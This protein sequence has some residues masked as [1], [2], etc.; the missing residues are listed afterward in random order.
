MLTLVQ[1]I[2]AFLNPF[3]CPFI[4]NTPIRSNVGT[5]SLRK[6]PDLPVEVWLEIF[7]FATYVHRNVTIK[8]LDPFTPKRTTTNAL[9]ANTPLSAMRTK[10]SL[11][12]VSKSWR[13]VAQQMLYEHIAIRSPPRA[14]IILNALKRSR[15][16]KDSENQKTN[17]NLGYGQFVRH[18]EVYTFARGSGEISY[19]QTVFKIL[20]YCPNLRTLSG[21][22][23]HY[24]PPEFLDAIAKLLGPSV[25]EFYWN[26]RDMSPGMK[27]NTST[28]P[29]FVGSFKA[30]RVLDLR[31]FVGSDPLSWTQSSSRPVLP[32]VQ[33]LILSTYSSSLD[34][35]AHLSL[36]CL[37]NLFLRTPVWGEKHEPSL[38]VFLKVHGP[39]LVVVDLT[40][41]SQDTEPIPDSS[42]P[43]RAASHIPPDIFLSPGIC[44]NLETLVFPVT[45]PIIAPHMHHHLRRIGL[46]GGNTEGLYPDK[47]TPMRN[48][49]MSINIEKYPKLELIQTV[50]FLVDAHTDSLIK[51]IFI[52]WVERFE[53]MGVDFLDGE[54]VLWAYTDPLPE[55]LPYPKTPLDAVKSHS[56]ISDDRVGK[57]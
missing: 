3:S 40:T 24:L 55:E 2:Q 30:L 44:P 52:W 53:A 37:R 33:D 13:N 42:V 20:N 57:D 10:L 14:N 11:V 6:L 45:S 47:V 35:A 41:P 22:W 27:N 29:T 43:G 15:T 8:P 16:P 25:S 4:V 21:N 12:L 51:D 23:R 50:G 56:D 28:A 39:S 18:I 9:G 31:H 17:P 1:Q 26:E 38:Q 34:I 5:K 46:R 19:L 32:H 7:Q 49:L 54:G 48:H 36:P